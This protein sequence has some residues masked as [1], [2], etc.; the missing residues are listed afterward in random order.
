MPPLDAVNQQFALAAGQAS[1][2]I[3]R[4][5]GSSL[6]ETV[7]APRT[8]SAGVLGPRGAD[9]LTSLDQAPSEPRRD[10]RPPAQ[11]L[12]G[13]RP[14]S[15]A[16]GAP[17]W[18]SLRASSWD[19]TI[20]M[21]RDAVA[22]AEP[23]QTAGA[24]PSESAS[25]ARAEPLSLAERREPTR[26]EGPRPDH[27]PVAAMARSESPEPGSQITETTGGEAS[28]AA[29]AR[30]PGRV[31]PGKPD[32]PAAGTRTD[33]PERA[34]S[35][36]PGPDGEPTSGSPPAYQAAGQ[37][38]ADA[39]PGAGARFVAA[40]TE[41]AGSGA[42]AR[43]E[44]ADTSAP[45][46]GAGRM[47]A[48]A[49]MQP[50]SIGGADARAPA[51]SEAEPAMTGRA[52][53]LSSGAS[54]NPGAAPSERVVAPAQPA[55][56]AVREAANSARIGR[57]ETDAQAPVQPESIGEADARAPARSE[58]ALAGRAP[59]P[60]SGAS[61]A[62]G[63]HLVALAEPSSRE[64]RGVANP[65]RIGLPETD[66][67]DVTPPT[68]Q[69]LTAAPLPLRT[70]GVA[71]SRSA[72][73]ASPISGDARNAPA[74]PTLLP[75]WTAPASLAIG[76][77]VE[78][79]GIIASFILNA[80]MI[81]GWPPPLPFAP[82]LEA[83]LL[84]LMPKQQASSEEG[85]IL[86]YIER[87]GV[88]PHGLAR[89]RDLLAGLAKSRRMRFLL[90]LAVLLSAIETVLEL[91]EEELAR[92]AGDAGSEEAEVTAFRPLIG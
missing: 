16:A 54:A 84:G 90:G 29:P 59:V 89:L 70:E 14:P 42:P 40:P 22:R 28:E 58:S 2:E 33:N 8:A 53:V 62:P 81:P 6:Q 23:D 55:P 38:T 46:E 85:D 4:N 61:A 50:E 78:R 64:A 67:P 18:P 71:L 69:A 48:R 52:P 21:P 9:D 39:A 82:T 41:P 92:L 88:K 49:P 86:A 83:R 24:S 45:P 15:A 32:A 25:A 73:S 80:A 51:R 47:A 19:R 56:P 3:A 77:Q 12:V 60:S 10:D 43:S 65:A 91:V 57:P 72:D 30:D 34:A 26:P 68:R 31:S 79:A 7:E 1:I 20:V 13:L 44:D 87:C 36:Q 63:E 75:D 76:G 66:A 74:D 37:R 27:A 17:A 35:A 11:S 5:I